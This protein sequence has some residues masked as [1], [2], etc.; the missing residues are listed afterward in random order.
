M[1]PAV[2]LLVSAAESVCGADLAPPGRQ[3]TPAPAAPTPYYIALRG[4]FDWA[5]DMAIKRGTTRIETQFDGGYLAAAGVG[6]HLDQVLGEVRGLRAEL[7]VGYLSR[8]ASRHFGASGVSKGAGAQ[9][10]VGTTYVLGSL[11]YDFM[12]EFWINPFVGAGA[13]FAEV[14]FEGLSG[15]V[16]GPIIDDRSTDLIYHG[17]AGLTFRLTP[18]WQLE[19]AYRYMTTPSVTARD[20]SGTRQHLN[21]TD[22]VL[23][24]GARAHF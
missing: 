4:G 12:P 22:Q 24:V 23:T 15:T 19:T 3:P 8:D 2:L 1:L 20:A 13:G 9:G 16:Q 5:E 14:A 21:L 17:T 7:E 18:R 6:V 11:Y 10:S